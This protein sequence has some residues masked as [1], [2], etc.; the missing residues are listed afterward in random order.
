[1]KSVR[2]PRDEGRAGRQW[3]ALAAV[4]LASACGP[5]R[6]QISAMGE[7]CTPMAPG[8][9]SEECAEGLCIALDSATGV[10][11]G[12]CQADQDCPDDFVCNAAGKY[13]RVCQKLAGCKEDVDCPSGH[14][15]NAVTGNCHIKVSRGLCSPCQDVAQCPEGGT[16]FK[17]VGSGE[18]FCTSPCLAGDVC[19]SGFGC[20]QIP[21]GP[22][23]AL[24]KQCVPT[25]RTCNQGKEL[26]AGCKGDLECGGQFDLCVRNVVSGE[27]FCGQD[28]NPTKNV[29]PT[30]GCDPKLLPTAS[31]P[32]CPTGFGCTNL[33]PGAD[34]G[35]WQC[36]PNSNTCGDYCNGTNE[37]DQTRQC[38]LGKTCTQ[39]HCVAAT[40]G[41][42]CAP[43][44][45]NDD[46]RKGDHPE[47][48]CLVNNCPDCQFKGETFCAT[49]CADD[50]ACVRSFGPGF[51]C[52]LVTEVNGTQRNYCIP[53]RGTCKSGL[54]RV[55]DDCSVN[56]AAECV[57]QV[58]LR[59]GTTAICSMACTQD[60][61]CGDSKFQCCEATSAGYDCS[62][63]QRGPTGP[64]SG[65]GVCAPIG[66][67]FGDDCSPGRPPC[68]SGTCLDLGTARLCT[69][70]CPG[71]SGCKA[72]FACRTARAQDGSGEV[73][74]CFPEGGGKAGAD[75]A[76]GPAACE[77]GLCIRKDSGPICTL[78]CPTGSGCPA[79]WSCEV[80][81]TV[82]EQSIQACI[83][84]S[85]LP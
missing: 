4:C 54:A 76:F 63:D 31:N 36:T 75:C 74:V 55:G 12:A 81:L 28:C 11:S 17:A 39:N 68:Q 53:Q 48:R 65:A 52:K 59:A 26:C 69:D 45:D 32:D 56:G 2:S 80:T 30:E 9:K 7:P 37:I 40:D 27:T 62:P 70:T 29:C 19:P 44:F 6:T 67:L 3:V 49:P 33:A 23:G 41:R 51:A 21:A 14:V 84:P 13:G 57:T 66:G 82:T 77:S 5:I 18:Q 42:E 72:G 35:I 15:C 34:D 64:K 83:P 10:C 61:Q 73:Q 20:E 85:L 78:P 8:L 60:S 46:C 16:C 38:G 47:N 71:G 24:V 79:E 1:V 25:A 58:C 22:A 50:A 43:C